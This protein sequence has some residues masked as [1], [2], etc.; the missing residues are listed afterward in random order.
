MYKR[1]Q[2]ACVSH[3]GNVR[4]N[5][6]DNYYFN[7]SY[8]SSESLGSNGILS[9]SKSF[10]FF[11]SSK[12]FFYAVFDGMGGGDY[13][14]IAS[15]KCAEETKR[16]FADESNI[17]YHD[18]TPTLQ[19]LCLN[20]ND[21]V[22]K[23]KQNLGVFQMGSTLVSVFLF[24]GLVWACNLGD[25][26]C[27]WYRE[28]TNQLMLASVDHVEDSLQSSKPVLTQYMGINP[29]DLRIDPSVICFEPNRNDKVILCS[30]GLT[31][32]VSESDIQE[33]LRLDTPNQSVEILL[34]KA[35]TA[36]GKDNI[37]MIVIKFS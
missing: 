36:G 25:S 20:L 15:F 21:S 27:Y 9:D 35:L 8:L 28:N 29:E 6:E 1:I 23:E 37:T 13:G 31:D 30:D 34:N 19:R 5:N 11:G 4:K 14:E 18:I 33:A 7:D 32:M 3:V 17:N 12:G 16:F 2:S 10:Q 22:C 26:R 24:A